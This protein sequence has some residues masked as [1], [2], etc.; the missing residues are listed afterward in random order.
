MTVIS[1]VAQLLY[2]LVFVYFLLLL[3]RLVFD[4]VQVFARDWRPRGIS[5]VVAESV[6]TATDPP[7]RFVRRWVKPL[8]LGAIQLDLAFLV[9]V[10]ACGVSMSLLSRLAAVANAATVTVGG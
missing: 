4:W 1:V 7:L 8:R 10:V 9:V 6:Y 5:L 2:V 3:C